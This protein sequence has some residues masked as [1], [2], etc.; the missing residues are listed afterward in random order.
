MK[1]VDFRNETW[2][3]VQQRVQSG[4]ERSQVWMALLEH[5]PA[6][7]RELA[8]AM[9]WTLENVRPR[10]TELYQAGFVVTT[11]ER[12][13]KGGVYRALRLDDAHRQFEQT[14]KELC[15]PQMEL[16]GLS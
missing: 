10:V 15:E 12:R 5:G 13:Q 1:P 2:A 3:E 14:R 16:E 4:E 6:T 11:G 9:G 7:T 8:D